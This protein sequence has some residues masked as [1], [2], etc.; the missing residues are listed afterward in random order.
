MYDTNNE[1]IY[2]KIELKTGEEEKYKNI[3]KIKDEQTDKLYVVKM[4]IKIGKLF[5]GLAGINEELIVYIIN[6]IKQLLW[7]KMRFYE[8]LLL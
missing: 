8:N 3:K 6:L 7:L 1:L 2:T 5:T 4:R